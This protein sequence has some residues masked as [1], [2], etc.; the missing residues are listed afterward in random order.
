MKKVLILANNAVGL[1]NFRFEL[2]CELIK[3]GL[4][5]YFAVP[6]SLEHKKVRLI[7]NAGAKYIHTYMN[8]RGSNPFEDIKLIIRYK[9]I[10]KE[11]NPDV[12]LTYTIKP[13]I[14]GGIAS[15]MCKSKVIH[16]VTGLGSVYIQDM[17][18]KNIVIFLN[19]IAFSN[20]SK[21]FFLNQDNEI[22][23]KKLNIISQNHNTFFWQT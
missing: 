23:Y 5:V 18:Q 19:R 4:E 1:Y 17:W 20:A 13:N 22:F 2:I 11:L 8:R 12:I 3:Q 9:K 14:Y 6:E 7:I 16:T 15:R 10:I 21:I